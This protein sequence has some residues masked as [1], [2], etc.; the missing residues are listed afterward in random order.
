[1]F[2]INWTNK[3]KIASIFEITQA[4]SELLDA[5]PS[6]PI[7]PPESFRFDANGGER[8]RIQSR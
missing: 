5:N 7:T 3:T 6:V 2:N 8:D 1:M 4:R